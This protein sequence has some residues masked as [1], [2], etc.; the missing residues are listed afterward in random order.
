MTTIINTK[1]S[2]LDKNNFPLS[3]GDMVLIDDPIKR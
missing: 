3:I 2:M 1:Y